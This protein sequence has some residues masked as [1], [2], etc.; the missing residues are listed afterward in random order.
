MDFL[1]AILKKLNLVSVPLLDTQPQ[2]CRTRALLEANKLGLF[3]ALENSGKGL[4]SDEVAQRIGISREGADVLLIA[5]EKSGYLEKRKDRYKNGRWV[6][7]WIIDPRRGIANFLRLQLHTWNR[8]SDLEVPLRTGKP[9]VDFHKHEVSV[10]S[11][12][13][14]IYTKAMRE[15]SRQLIPEFL[16]KVKLP[17]DAK[18]LLDIGGAHGEYSR[19]LVQKFPG[20]KATIL[21]FAGP[22]ATAQRILK[23]KGN[24]EALELRVG[25]ALNDNIGTGWDAVLLVNMVHLFNF[26]QNRK[27]I[28]RIHEALSPQGVII[29]V[30]QFMGIGRLQDKFVSL[31]SLNYFT[32]GGKCYHREE[33]RHLFKTAGFNRIM[34]KPFR[35]ISPTVLFEGWK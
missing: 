4:G 16:K 19:A 1:I 25:D 3:T 11:E 21:D 9:V 23:Q 6:K 20:L 12:R 18:R 31:I 7:R 2:I 15:M 26:K 27:L 32:L 34:V 14:E 29:V 24:P 13:Q 10:H 8:L 22:I 28:S 35:L 30:D 5:L 17:N 33:M